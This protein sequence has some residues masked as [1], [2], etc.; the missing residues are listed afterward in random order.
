MTI[1]HAVEAGH[2]APA[3]STEYIAHHLAHLRNDA[4][5]LNLDTFWVSALLGL[6]FLLVFYIASRRAT[7]GVPGK[8]QNFVEMIMEMVNDTI[9]GAFHAK[10]KIIAPLAIT[11][12]VWVWLLNAMDFLPVDLLPKVL[13]WFGVHKLRVVPTADVNHTFAMSF[14]VVLCVI[15]FSIKAKGLGGWI[16]EL[17]T[18]PFHASGLVGTIALAPVNFLLQ[19]VELL[20]KLISLSLRLFGNMYA[21]ELIFI[22]I[23]LL[24]WWAQWALGGPWAIFHILIV[25]LQAFVFMALTV[26]YLSLAVEKH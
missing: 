8:L 24:P 20:A 9:N 23:A 12:F 21:G 25:T 19:M 5:T 26:V 3:N 6:V 2:A 4:G 14:S 1:E 22:L 16:K 10:S 11:I 18:A 13:S 17:F 15:A 7:A